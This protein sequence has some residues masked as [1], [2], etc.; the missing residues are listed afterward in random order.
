MPGLTC[1]TSERIG[2]TLPFSP[3][4]SPTLASWRAIRT[5]GSCA[6]HPGIHLGPP[7]PRICCLLK[8]LITLEKRLGV[9]GNLIWGDLAN[10]VKVWMGGSKTLLRW[11]S[12]VRRLFP[13]EHLAMRQK[14]SFLER[15][16]RH[17][18]LET[19]PSH[20]RLIIP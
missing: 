15:A 18:L 3:A 9:V 1:T 16:W 6:I 19:I 8:P 12:N 14:F 20:S 10:A 4:L 17:R 11:K 7:A 13:T 5:P 2:K